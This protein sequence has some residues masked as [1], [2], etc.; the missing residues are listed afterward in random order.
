MDTA[1]ALPSAAALAWFSVT[2]KL[3]ATLSPLL[4]CTAV[5][6]LPCTTCCEPC[7]KS[8]LRQQ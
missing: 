5:V 6:A 8:A 2:W 4:Q 3:S 7:K 1:S